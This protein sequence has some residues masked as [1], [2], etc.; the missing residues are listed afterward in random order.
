M[1]H[2]LEGDVREKTLRE[3]RRV[4]KPGGFL[5]VRLRRIA[6][7]FRSR[8]IQ[9]DSLKQTLARQFRESNSLPHGPGRVLRSE[10]DR[11]AAPSLRIWL[12][13]VLSGVRTERVKAEQN[14]VTDWM[15]RQYPVHSI[16]HLGAG[17]LYAKSVLSS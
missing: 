8:A 17:P 15:L 7:R 14:I 13:R 1:F 3:V 12:C 9:P 16:R 6:V 10:E 2:H 4:L 5:L 11:S